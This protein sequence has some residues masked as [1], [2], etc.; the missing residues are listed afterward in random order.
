MGSC[1]STRA[2]IV[3]SNHS[4]SSDKK[5][6]SKTI[7]TIQTSSCPNVHHITKN[8]S[9]FTSQIDL[10]NIKT[11]HNPHSISNQILI[12]LS[13]FKQGQ[14]PSNRIRLLDLITS[15]HSSKNL[16]PICDDILLN[17]FHCIKCNLFICEHCF[18]E[19]NKKICEHKRDEDI[20]DYYKNILLRFRNCVL[21]HTC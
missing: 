14:H 16:C 8:K 12:N 17:P 7:E 3:V 19:S 9:Q 4:A 2:P 18:T 11:N 6:P 20:N 5:P 1:I 13:L 15:S 21:L 10:S